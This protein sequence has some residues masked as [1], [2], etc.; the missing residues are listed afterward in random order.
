MLVAALLAPL[1]AA[2]A[3]VIPLR[4]PALSTQIT[5]L[6]L[7]CLSAPIYILAERVGFEPT[8]TVRCY[9]LS[10]RA[11]STARPPLHAAARVPEVD[12]AIKF[13]VAP[14][15]QAAVP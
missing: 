2:L 15:P 13:T 1:M 4:R 6:K 14:S 8:N 3:G 5:R 11:P 10:R 7:S 9:T 12:Q